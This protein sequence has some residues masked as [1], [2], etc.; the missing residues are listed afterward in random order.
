MSRRPTQLVPPGTL[1]AAALDGADCSV[2]G[3]HHGRRAL[4]VARWTGS[5]DATDRFVLAHCLGATIDLGCGPG[6]M[7]AELVRRGHDVLGVDISAEA[8]R[9]A[10][11]RGVVA[12]RRNLLRRLPGEGR[13]QTALLADGNIG[14][15]GDPTALLTRVRALVAPGGRVVVD[16][17]RPGTGIRVH[18]LQ[19]VVGDQH[20]TPFPW[21]EVDGEALRPVA[22]AAGLCLDE[23][24]EWGGRWVAVLTR[25]SAVQR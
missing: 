22:V 10:R 1:F 3:H 5:A 19:L 24:S 9:R 12:V 14:I 18:S 25:P 23:V 6:R 7:A 11:S 8:V 13:W 16:L 21:A 4:H 15:G 20:S 17:A 2:V